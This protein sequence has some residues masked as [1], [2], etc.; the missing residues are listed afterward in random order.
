[1]DAKEAV[2]LSLSAWWFSLL[3]AFFAMQAA[4]AWRMDILTSVALLFS[5]PQGAVWLLGWMR[6]SGCEPRQV[7]SLA[8][9]L[10]MSRLIWR[11]KGKRG[12]RTL[13][14]RGATL[15]L[16]AATPVLLFG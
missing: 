13:D 12:M 4:L 8:A 9:G 15:G 7:A 2:P 16:C 5:A 14:L 6:R 3:P 1:P 10:L 11:R